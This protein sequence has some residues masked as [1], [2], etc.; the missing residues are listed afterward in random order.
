M[1]T[2]YKGG[3]VY[4]FHGYFD[5]HVIK[6]IDQFLT[7]VITVERGGGRRYWSFQ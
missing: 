2:K 7:L 4:I 3:K 1:S 5:I 6:V